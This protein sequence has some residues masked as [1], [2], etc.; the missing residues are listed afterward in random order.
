MSPTSVSLDAAIENLRGAGDWSLEADSRRSD[1]DIVEFEREAGLQVPSQLRSVLKLYDWN[2]FDRPDKCVNFSVAFDHGNRSAHEVQFLVSDRKRFQR[3]CMF[4]GNA[5][6]PGQFTLYQA[7]MIGTHLTG[8][9]GAEAEERG[10][11]RCGHRASR[12][13]TSG[14]PTKPIKW[15]PIIAAWYDS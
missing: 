11:A 6:S 15:V 10:D 12:A 8:A 1:R 9:I 13:T 14:E 2:G 4:I 7:A 5:S 3:H